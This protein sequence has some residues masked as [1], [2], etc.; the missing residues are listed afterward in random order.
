[1][2]DRK[3]GMVF[4]SWAIVLAFFFVMLSVQVGH[5]YKRDA[6]LVTELKGDASLAQ[7]DLPF[8]ALMKVKVGDSIILGDGATMSIVF[9]RSGR[10]ETWLGPATISIALE[11]GVGVN[12]SKDIVPGVES[13]PITI[14]RSLTRM[15]QSIDV[16]S[17]QKVG[18]VGMRAAGEEEGLTPEQVASLE[19]AKAFYEEMVRSRRGTD[20]IPEIYYISELLQY[21]QFEEIS[22]VAD[23]ALK[24]DPKNEEMLKLKRIAENR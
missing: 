7:A 11:Q 1:M 15:P 21:G 17:L 23:V 14:A 10:K 19:K 9:F 6:G 8:R 4:R 2:S 20:V 12:G 22:K 18:G 24:I 13:L 3:R 16:K 5:A